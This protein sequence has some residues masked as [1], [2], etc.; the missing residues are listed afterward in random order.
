MYFIVIISLGR[1]QHKVIQSITSALTSLD[2]LRGPICVLV[3]SLH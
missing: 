3:I 2:H 1:F